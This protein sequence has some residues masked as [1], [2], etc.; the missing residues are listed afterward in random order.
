M[1]SGGVGADGA[2]REGSEA[3]RGTGNGVRRC[4]WGEQVL[5]S[6]S[7]RE[8]RLVG[9]EE[10]ARGNTSSSKDVTGNDDAIGGEVKT[11][12]PLV[13]RGVTKEE[14]GSGAKR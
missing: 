11:V 4:A 3:A 8:S 13:V 7:R 2:A 9:G 6:D 12:I 5:R 14:V 10:P 1:A